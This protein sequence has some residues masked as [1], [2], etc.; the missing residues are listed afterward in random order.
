MTRSDDMAIKRVRIREFIQNHGLGG[1]L[2]TLQKNF[3]WYTSGGRGYIATTTDKSAGQ[4]LATPNQDYLIANNIETNRFLNE[5]GL[6]ELGIR[7][8]SYRWDAD[9]SDINQLTERVLAGKKHTTDVG[10][11]AAEIDHLRYSL[12]P[13]EVERYRALGRDC[14]AAMND[15]ARSIEPGMTEWQIAGRLQCALADKQ[16]IGAVVLVA[17]DERIS[18]YR[19]PI[20]TNKRLENR[21]LLVTCGRR[22]GLIVSLSRMVSFGAVSDDLRRRHDACMA[23]DAT[24]IESTTVGADVD[25]IVQK[26]I[27]T[28]E[29][30]G[31]TEEWTLHHQGG[32]TG[33]ETRD[34]RGTLHSKEVV[35]PW[36][37]YAWNPSI[38]GTKTEDT[39]I[40]TPDGPEIVSL[41]KDWP[42]KEFNTARGG[43]RI[44]RP[45]ILVR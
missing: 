39:I 19:H 2:F 24:F 16:V 4:I 45:D 12:T 29:E 30:H 25:E 42:V 8:L 43:P 27:D 18:L 21:A 28:Y 36:Q 9:A 3:S 1:V 17:A 7:P 14:E 11:H 34:F 32:G 33:Y 6:G 5:E 20:P 23:V 41:S 15:V 31:F 44:V 40:A 13:L 10:P 35:Q 38:T 37:A 26:A 22:H